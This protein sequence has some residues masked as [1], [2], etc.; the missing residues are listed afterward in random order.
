MSSERF[1]IALSMREIAN[2]IQDEVR[3][4]ISRDVLKFLDRCNFELNLIPNCEGIATQIMN[5][6]EIQGVI[7][8]GGNNIS[9]LPGEQWKPYDVSE[10]RDRTERE[11][12]R[13]CMMKKLPVLAICR[14]FHMLNVFFNGTIVRDLQTLTGVNHVATN[15]PI[16]LEERYFHFSGGRKEISINSFHQQGITKET[17]SE[18]LQ[19]LALCGDVVEAAHHVNLPI[20]GIQWHPERPGSD[21]EL[22]KAIVEGFCNN[23]VGLW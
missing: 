9:P 11:L 12:L 17:L 18:K 7:L 21:E 4:A 10:D 15:H 13:Y 8:S 19:V 3:D 20:L 6:E 14:G 1:K 23:Y 22:D 16:C 5:T 2:S